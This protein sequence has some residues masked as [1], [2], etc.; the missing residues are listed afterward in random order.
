MNG[1]HEFPLILFTVLAQVAA[2]A[3]L[4]LLFPVAGAF[5]DKQRQLQRGLWPILLFLAIGFSAS[6]M[7]LGSPWRAFNSLNRVGQSMLSNEI[8][9]GALFF[10]LAG[11]YWLLALMEKM[12]KGLGRLWL[13]LSG[14]ASL[15]F[16]Y[17]MNRVYHIPTVPTWD[18][19]FTTF[20]FYLTVVLGGTALAAPL[21]WRV[22]DKATLLPKLFL[23]G[24]GVAA[25]VAVYQGFEFAQLRTGVTS[26]VALVPDYAYLTALR[27]CLLAVAA[28]LLWRRKVGGAVVALCLTLLAEMI[29]R[30]LFYAMHMT[31]GTTF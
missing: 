27:L 3:W 20:N 25:I 17:V 7:H 31:L 8:A 5:A 26:F 14:L 9:C 21:L 4:L 23:C 2:G 28:C 15:A 18:N 6:I 24:L 12:P 29:G 13:P 22:G 10:A 16:M 30:S 1:L 19:L 11:S